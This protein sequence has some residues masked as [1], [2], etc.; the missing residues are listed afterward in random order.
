MSI[1]RLTE[2][3]TKELLKILDADSDKA[4]DVSQVVEKAIIEAVRD[5]NS[6]C[7]DVVRGCCSEDMDLA[8]KIAR[9]IELKQKALIANLSSMR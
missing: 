5:A 7:V 3:V 4:Q 6:Q 8:H 1:T 2:D 9:E